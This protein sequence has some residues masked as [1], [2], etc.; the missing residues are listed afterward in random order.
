MI[1]SGGEVARVLELF[2]GF[3]ELKALW[4]LGS[5]VMWEVRLCSRSFLCV[6]GYLVGI[7]FGE[8]LERLRSKEPKSTHSDSGARMPGLVCPHGYLSDP[9]QGIYFL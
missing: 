1:F 3:L 7:G 4:G 8:L 6:L 9:G 2:R 5:F